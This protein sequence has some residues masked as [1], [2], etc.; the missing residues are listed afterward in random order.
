MKSQV[1]YEIFTKWNRK[2]KNG[3]ASDQG[4]FLLKVQLSLFSNWDLWL[5]FETGKKKKSIF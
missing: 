4:S 2:E 5:F 1:R 3:S